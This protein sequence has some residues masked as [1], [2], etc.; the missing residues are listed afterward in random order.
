VYCISSLSCGGSGPSWIDS[1][2][3]TTR[4]GSNLAAKAAISGRPLARQ[5]ALW[6]WQNGPDA[7][8][9]SSQCRMRQLAPAG[10]CLIFGG[11]AIQAPR[12]G[13]PARS[14]R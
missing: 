8:G 6:E 9:Q 1:S 12:S 10:G 2:A 5:V 13:R 11:S 14:Q 4:P 7:S 3:G